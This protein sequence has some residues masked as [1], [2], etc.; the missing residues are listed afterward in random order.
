M[1]AM[2][3]SLVTGSCGAQHNKRDCANRPTT[4]PPDFHYNPTL[5][6]HLEQCHGMNENSDHYSVVNE[7]L[8]LGGSDGAAPRLI[9]TLQHI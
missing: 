9:P 1:V 3:T 4:L 8:S 2:D 6:A 7:A 5:M